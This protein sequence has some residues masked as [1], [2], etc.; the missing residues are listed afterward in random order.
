MGH[1]KSNVTG[2]DCGKEWAI[3]QNDMKR[4]RFCMNRAIYIGKEGMHFT[5]SFYNKNKFG[6]QLPFIF[7]EDEHL[8]DF[9]II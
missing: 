2:Q 8:H 1:W 9:K 5:E 3:A 6:E 4:Y 7:K